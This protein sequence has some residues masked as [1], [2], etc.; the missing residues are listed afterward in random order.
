M[1][2]HVPCEENGQNQ[3]SHLKQLNRLYRKEENY[4]P[5]TRYAH[6]LK[7]FHKT[8]SSRYR[9]PNNTPGFYLNSNW[10]EDITAAFH[11]QFGCLLVDL[12]KENFII[13]VN[14][15]TK[16]DKGWFLR[17]TKKLTLKI[18][19]KLLE[20]TQSLPNIPHLF[21]CDQKSRCICPLPAEGC[22]KKMYI[23]LREESC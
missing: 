10:R 14:F 17:P 3:W 22:K 8:R 11:E 21:S 16:V 6:L 18:T 12:L 2:N 4:L 1:Q 5:F 13:I 23:S 7:L 19:K 20:L 15:N 9:S